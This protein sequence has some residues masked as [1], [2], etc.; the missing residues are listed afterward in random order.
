IFSRFDKTT[1]AF[2]GFLHLAGAL[3][4]MR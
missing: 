2:S 3:I 1:S 4:W